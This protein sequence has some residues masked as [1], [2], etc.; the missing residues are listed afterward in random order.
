MRE[1]IDF[2]EVYKEF[3]PK[4]FHYLSRL[5]GHH[6]A[7]DLAQEVFNKVNRDL[8]G[9][10]NREIAD[11]LHVSLETV[12]TRFHLTRARLKNELGYGCDFYHNEQDILG[13]DRKLTFIKAKKPD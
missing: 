9:F 4:I 2:T 5:A 1:E 6:E 12:K 3:Q 13:C 8:E 10:K 7:E 11:I